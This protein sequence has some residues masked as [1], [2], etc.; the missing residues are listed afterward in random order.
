MVARKRKVTVGKLSGDKI[1]ITS[2]L[3]VGD[4][5]ITDGYQS[6]Y[7]GQLITTTAV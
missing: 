2:G 3:Q 7:D 6:L 4:Q 1:Q 5:L